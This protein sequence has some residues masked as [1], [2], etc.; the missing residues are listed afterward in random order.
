MTNHTA[1][2]IH[3]WYNCGFQPIQGQIIQVATHQRVWT[4]DTYSCPPFPARAL[5][6]DISPDDAHTYNF[7]AD[8]SD[9]NLPPGAYQVDVQLNWTQGPDSQP[10]E[11][12]YPSGQARGSAVISL[13]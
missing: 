13:Q 12:H 4:S 11:G 10:P 7:V 9:M 1:A 3:V 5:P 8:L 6:P 2:P